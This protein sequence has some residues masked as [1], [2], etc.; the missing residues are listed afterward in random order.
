MTRL[1]FLAAAALI[2]LGGCGGND[3]PSATLT[4]PPAST[5]APM[6]TS[7]PS[8]MATPTATPSPTPRPGAETAPQGTQTYD[9]QLDLIISAVL[10]GN[11]DALVL[12]YQTTI[13]PCTNAVSLGG[14]PK[15]AYAP[16]PPTDGKPVAAIPVAGCEGGW[17]FDVREIAGLL[18]DAKPRLY[19]VVQFS[20]PQPPYKK[21][22]GYPLM[23]HLLLWEVVVGS[24]N[25]QGIALG[26]RNGSIVY[27]RAT[28]GGPVQAILNDFDY[29][30][31]ILRGPAYQ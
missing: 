16:G 17:A 11:A 5:T 28:C 22:P 8:A 7:T 3:T 4:P 6:N 10:G 19:G 23:D 18:V 1:A 27:Q 21:E 24:N 31:V 25:P 9:P 20:T 13:M 15:C 26:L 14:P 2:L 30:R 12:R 29:Y